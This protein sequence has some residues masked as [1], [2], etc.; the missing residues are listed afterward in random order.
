MNFLQLCQR[1]SLEGGVSGSIT[2]TANQTGEAARII[3]WVA[4]AYTEILNDQAL[5]WDFLQKTSQVQLT[6]GKGLYSFTDLGLTDGVQWDENSM[7]VAVNSDMS[8]ETFLNGMRFPEYRDYWLFSS[9]RT[10]ESRPLDVAIDN[11]TLL[12]IAPIPDQDY[13]LALQYQAMP[14]ELINDADTPDIIPARYH[15]AIVWRA[16]RHYGMFEAAPEVV[17]RADLAYRELMLQLELDEAD[18]VIVGEPLC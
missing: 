10:T 11:E 9:R 8:D 14:A 16:L 2:S 5:N 4:S 18:E 7:R 3:T 6:S 17:T 1:T 12:N 15:L 13:Y